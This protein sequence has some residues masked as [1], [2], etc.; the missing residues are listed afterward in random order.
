M[1]LK[2]KSFLLPFVK[3]GSWLMIVID[4]RNQQML[5]IRSRA[6]NDFNFNEPVIIEMVDR[7]NAIFNHNDICISNFK[8]LTIIG[9]HSVYQCGAFLTY[10]AMF[11][12][13]NVINQNFEEG[14]TTCI[15]NKEDIDEFKLKILELLLSKMI[16]NLNHIRTRN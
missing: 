9:D 1:E 13:N 10:V 5:L 14:H 11:L 6:R 15:N 2:T 7:L 4:C 8:K 12:A 3:L 16:I